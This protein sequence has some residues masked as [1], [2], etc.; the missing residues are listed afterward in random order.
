MQVEG[1]IIHQSRD[2]MGELCI[3]DTALFRCL[4]FGT[5][6]KQSA[7]LK[8]RPDVL[9]L[10]YTQAMATAMALVPDPRRILIL[11]MGGGSLAKF[12]LQNF[13][14]VHIDAVEIRDAVIKLA[15][16][17]FALPEYDPRLNITLANA[18]DF[19]MHQAYVQRARYDLIFIDLFDTFGPSPVLSTRE[20]L[21]SC[22]LLLEANGVAVINAWNRPQDN[23]KKL[24][25]SFRAQIGQRAMNLY[26][27]RKNS[28]VVSFCFNHEQPLRIVENYLQNY[29]ISRLGFGLDELKYLK[30]LYRQNT[31][32]FTRR[33]HSA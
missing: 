31:S 2:G 22:D 15:L 8:E 29:Q 27:G 25:R 6:D 19:V 13:P 16:G 4:Y 11:G 23:Y 9:V 28:N 33:R 26:L 3:T 7:M 14:E 1:Q 10:Q 20:F 17:Y 12:L 21:T 32:F 24:N 18:Q 5:I 30:M